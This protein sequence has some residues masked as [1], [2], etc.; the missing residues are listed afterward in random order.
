MRPR[1]FSLFEMLVVVIA[2]GILAGFAFER[3]LPLV[4]KA[5]RV[6]F[7]QVRSQLQSALLL[8]TAARIARGESRLLGNLSGR[9][10]MELLLQAPANYLGV[11]EPPAA[12]RVP[13]RRWY[14]DAAAERLVYRVG[15]YARFDGLDGPANRIELTVRMVYQDR[16]GDGLF[17]P[18]IDDFG[19]MR[20][21]SVHAFSWP[22]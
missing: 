12:G 20:L 17:D 14:Y 5:E 11:L 21:A 1:G 3:L 4:G 6:A 15:P 22:E 18:R 8:E 19:G 16:D 2:I 10:P 7:L 13:A 9:N